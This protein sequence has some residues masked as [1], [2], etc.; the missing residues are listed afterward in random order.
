M[1]TVELRKLFRRPR[2]WAALVLLVALPVIV[3]ILL[4][5]TK[6]APRPGQGPAFLSAVLDNGSLFGVAALAIVL[7]LF[8]PISVA[9]IAGESIAGEAQGGTLRYLLA[10]PVGRTKLLVAKLMAVFAFVAVAVLL[11]AG[12]GFLIGRLLFGV[13][14]IPASTFSGTTLTSQ[15]ILVRS[16]LAIGYVIVSMLGIAAMALALSTA[17]DSPLSA[18]LGALALL[19]GSSLLLTLDA[20][21]ALKPYLPTR[22]WLSFVD[23]FRDPILWRNVER[24]LLLQL[25]Y[26]AV[27]LGIAWANFASKDITS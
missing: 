19:I 17:T 25:V 27:L 7:P 21:N 5:I 12:S 16:V 11:V 23:L 2:T 4:D 18:T 14:A 15:Q 6:L 1:I 20:A 10:R 26:V 3:A 24:G 9:V 22:Y 13:S 8:L